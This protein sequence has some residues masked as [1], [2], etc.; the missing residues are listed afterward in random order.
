MS[1]WVHPSKGWLCR[2]ALNSRAP[3]AAVL[4]KGTE[5][6]ILFFSKQTATVM[7]IKKKSLSYLQ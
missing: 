3:L 5:V 4:R 2:V 7:L 1:S 6:F